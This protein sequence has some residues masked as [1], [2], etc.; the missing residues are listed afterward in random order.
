[1]NFMFNISFLI[2]VLC[3]GSN[4]ATCHKNTLAFQNGLTLSQSTLDVHCKSKDNDLGDHFVN[5]KDPAYNFSFHDNVVFTTKFNCG[6]YWSSDNHVYRQTF[7]AYT[8][9]LFRCGALFVW[10]ARDDALYLSENGKPE[11]LMYGWIIQ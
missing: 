11:K 3:F 1:M 5:F 9:G 10:N 7:V 8:G 2:V 4:E 6:L